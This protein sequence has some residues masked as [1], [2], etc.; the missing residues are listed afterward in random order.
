MCREVADM[1]NKKSQIW[2]IPNLL[3]CVRL[4][5]IPVFVGIYLRAESAADYRMAAAVILLSG[6][7]DALDGFIARRFHMITELGKALDP[8][9]DK[10]T[11]AAILICLMFRYP[12]MAALV[13]ILAARDLFMGING[14][15]LLR[16]GK[17]L[18]GAK[19]F[20]KV[21]TAVFYVSTFVLILVPEL[22]A[23]VVRALMV[24]VG[25]FLILSFVLYFPLF[26]KMYRDS[27]SEKQRGE[28]R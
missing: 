21:S 12:A 9:A 13:A 18:D 1:E 22:P 20:G 16:R 23:A 24:L 27:A 14:L 3:S 25:F 7:T 4:A 15:I 19:W 26:V 6:F 2:S 8:V 17:K 10:L 5:L 11:Q 28:E